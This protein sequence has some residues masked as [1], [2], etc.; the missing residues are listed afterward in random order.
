M[1]MMNPNSPFRDSRIAK[2]LAKAIENEANGNHYKIME[3]CGTHTMSIARNGLRSVLPENVELVSGPGCPVCVT[4]QGEIDLFFDVID[5]G[6][7]VVTFGDLLKI[8][9]SKGRSL[10]TLRAEGADVRVIYSPLD[11]LEMAKKEPEKNFVFL[12]VGFETTAPTIAYLAKVAKENGYKNISVLSVCKTMPE[13]IKVILSDNDLK[14]DGFLCPGHVTTVTGI[15]LY[16]DIINAKKAAVVAGF[17]PVEMLDA[18]L[19]II[20]QVNSKNFHISNKYKRV[21]N[22][23]GNPIARA[24]LA[25]IFKPVTVSWRGIGPLENSGLDFRDEYADFDAKKVYNITYNHIDEIK[26]CKCGAVLT[27]KIKPTDCKLFGTKCNTE[28][29]IGPCMVSS[30]GTCAAY[31]RFIS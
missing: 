29:P 18:I 5:K 13:A 24:I 2:G 11:T 4:S 28:N 16:D 12:G 10:S 15:S 23:D 20:K 31:Y 22:K 1:K 17:E 9:N 25:E 3:I 7:T 14:L 26:G 19:E 6:A 8:P 21:V 30:E 27:G